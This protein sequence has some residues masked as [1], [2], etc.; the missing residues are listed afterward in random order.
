V[1]SGI[2]RYF[3]LLT[4]IPHNG[5]EEEF[6]QFM[7]LI[8]D[9]RFEGRFR[10]RETHLTLRSGKCRSFGGFFRRIRKGKDQRQPMLNM[11]S[12]RHRG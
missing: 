8:D 9:D 4:A 2:K 12:M 7:A 1:P 3:L 10:D 11:P 6:Q 5:K